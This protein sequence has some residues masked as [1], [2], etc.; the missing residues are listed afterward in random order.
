MFSTWP[1]VLNRTV[2]GFISN[3]TDG[4]NA[5]AYGSFDTCI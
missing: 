2:E 3:G 4:H 1:Q 5:Q